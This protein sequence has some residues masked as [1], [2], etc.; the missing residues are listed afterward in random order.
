MRERGK[1]REGQR[2]RGG[3]KR[4]GSDRDTESVSLHL[5]RWRWRESEHSKSTKDEHASSTTSSVLYNS[6]SKCNQPTHKFTIRS[7]TH[8]YFSVNS[9]A[10]PLLP[11]QTTWWITDL[12]NASQASQRHNI[13]YKSK[14]TFHHLFIKHTSHARREL[15]QT[16]HV[17]S[18][19]GYI[20][21]VST[22][23]LDSKGHET[24]SYIFSD[25]GLMVR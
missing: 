7:S 25:I 5:C 19:L 21:G 20:Y 2:G 8:S 23:L 24:L 16:L 11:D 6:H 3:E 18:R 9:P 14:S 12:L 10:H 13:I 15:N 22:Q 17:G 4:K 1:E